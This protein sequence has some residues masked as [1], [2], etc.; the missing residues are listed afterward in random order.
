MGLYEC[1]LELP[2][3]QWWSPPGFISSPWQLYSQETTAG[4]SSHQAPSSPAA[5]AWSGGA[6]VCAALSWANSLQS[7]SVPRHQRRVA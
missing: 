1:A 7:L 5:E 4:E 2:F 3:P 6:H